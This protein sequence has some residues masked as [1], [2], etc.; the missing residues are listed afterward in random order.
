MLEAVLFDLDDT[1]LA[2]D[3]D[4]FVPAYLELLAA[5]AQSSIPSARFRAALLA[6]TRAM[7]DSDDPNTTNSDEFWARFEHLLGAEARKLEAHLL[8][9]YEQGFPMLAQHTSPVP[10][11]QDLV[12]YCRARGWTLVVAT[13]P[14][15]PRTANVQRLRWAGLSEAD[16]ALITSYETSRATKPRSLYYRD[17]L[18]GIGCPPNAALM[19]GNS[20]SADIQPAAALGMHT[21]LVRDASKA[22]AM[23]QGAAQPARDA[24]IPNPFAVN[25]PPSAEAGDL[26]SLRQK[27]VDGWLA[28]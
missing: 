26:V 5:H 23:R 11:A 6:S 18:S 12:A 2:N 19:V 13:N 4:V 1:L 27:L 20:V 17:I 25:E 7:F 14:I 21:Y 3:M 24:D 16:F 22:L 9:F 8:S 28:A 10:G 15:F